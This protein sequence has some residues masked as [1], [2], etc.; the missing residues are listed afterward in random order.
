[1]K[2][3]Y[4]GWEL[5]KEISEGNIK[6]GTKIKSDDKDILYF[7]GYNLRYGDIN[8]QYFK[9]SVDD[10]YFGNCDFELIEEQEEINI[11]DIEEFEFGEVEER[12]NYET[13]SKINEIIR[14]LKQL[15]KKIKENK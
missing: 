15:D 3:V 1:M 14:Y 12:N 5:L 2:K 13:R 11:Q 10:V 4:K 9:E 6:E 7:D 8:G